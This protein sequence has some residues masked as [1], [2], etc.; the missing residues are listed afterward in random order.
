MI[1]EE[2]HQNAMTAP[3]YQSDGVTLYHGD[4]ERIPLNDASIDLVFTSPPYC[5]ARHYQNKKLHARGCQDWI[6]WM[7]KVVAECTRVCQGLVL[8]NCAGVTRDRI[9]Q[10]GPEGLI[11]EWWKRGGHCWRPAY[12]HRVGIPGSG[13][14]HWLRADIEYV[15][16]F[17]RDNEWPAWSD[18][19][20][21]GHKPKWGPGGEMS[22]RLSDGARVNQWGR[23]GEPRSMGNVSPDNKTRPR[24]RPSH[25]EVDR[26]HA[27]YQAPVLANPGNVVENIPVGGGC[28]GDEMASLNEAPF[29]EKFAAWFIRSFCPPGG[30]VLDPFCGSGSCLAAA[31]K[32]GRRGIG[33]DIRENQCELTKRR[34]AAI[35][36]TLFG[37]TP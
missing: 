14:K 8:I 31:V 29:P 25:R 34:L 30:T 3:Y 18:N 24:S 15:L 11:Y 4:A 37:A 9:Y 35:P 10:P 23:V 36:P 6:D 22:H 13:G 1:I 27:A 32:E 26:E 20:A 33:M 12:W 2:Q 16:C 5:D 19:T 17:K 28:M 21:N 7:L